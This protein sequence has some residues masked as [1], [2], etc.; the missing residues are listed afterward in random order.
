[1]ARLALVLCVSEYDHWLPLPGAKADKARITKILEAL[2]F[3]VSSPGSPDAL[4]GYVSRAELVSTIDGFLEEVNLRVQ[5]LEGVIALVWYSGHGLGLGQDPY[6]NLV[7]SDANAGSSIGSIE[8]SD[9]IRRLNKIN[10]S[11]PVR[12]ITIWDCCRENHVDIRWKGHRKLLR[13]LRNDFYTIFACDPGRPAA[14]HEGGGAL[15]RELISLLPYAKPISAIFL[16]A[17]K[18]VKCERPWVEA[19]PGRDEPILGD[20]P[21]ELPVPLPMLLGATQQAQ[22]YDLHDVSCDSGSDEAES[23]DFEVARLYWTPAM[24]VIMMA[25]HSLLLILWLCGTVPKQYATRL[26]M[27]PTLSLRTMASMLHSCREEDLQRFPCGSRLGYDRTLWL[28][29]LGC[30]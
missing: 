3:Q 24:A 26:L 8:S 29:L 25:S 14:D 17:A 20:Q 12:V 9:L 15:T 19:R 28:Q 23:S 11:Q 7:P 21:G 4:N 30:L 16:E 22:V 6:P 13:R 2:G 10:V 27:P 18:R 5:E 1:M